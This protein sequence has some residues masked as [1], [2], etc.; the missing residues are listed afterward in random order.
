M[1]LKNEFC[2][3]SLYPLAVSKSFFHV[4][5]IAICMFHSTMTT[6]KESASS[7]WNGWWSKWDTVTDKSSDKKG[8]SLLHFWN[9]NASDLEPHY[10]L[11]GTPGSFPGLGT[12]QGVFQTLVKNV[13]HVMGK[14]LW[15]WGSWRVF[16]MELLPAERWPKKGFLVRQEGERSGPLPCSSQFYKC[17]SRELLSRQAVVRVLHSGLYKIP[18]FWGI[19]KGNLSQR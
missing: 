9:H 12:T 7:N 14:I 13:S 4:A 8:N 15:F 18:T 2:G 1:G 5:Q 10:T 3:C 11:L 16:K 6:L 17:L 19:G